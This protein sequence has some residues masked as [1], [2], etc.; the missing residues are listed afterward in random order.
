MEYAR[1]ALSGSEQHAASQPSDTNTGHLAHSH[2]VL[3]S[4]HAKLGDWAEAR[5][6]A[7]QAVELWRPIRNPGVLAMDRKEMAEALALA[8]K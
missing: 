6:A 2:F 7:Q 3:A 1:R 4:V 5:R 8:A